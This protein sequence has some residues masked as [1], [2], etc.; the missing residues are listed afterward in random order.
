MK[1][2][3]GSTLFV[4]LLA[5]DVACT[6]QV[7]LGGYTRGAATGS[8]GGVITDANGGGGGGSQ[9]G[10]S[11]SGGCTPVDDGNPC[12]IDV[13]NNGAPANVPL[14][15]GS[16][17]GGGGADA[18]VSLCNAMAECVSTCGTNNYQVA[19]TTDLGPFGDPLSLWVSDINRD[20]FADVAT[21]FPM[22]FQLAPYMGNGDGY[23][24]PAPPGSVGALPPVAMALADVNSDGLLDAVVVG[25]NSDP[26]AG[27]S[28]ISVFL[29]EKQ[30]NGIAFSASMIVT[31]VPA[32]VAENLT[33]N[34]FDADGF[35]DVAIG[36][37]PLVG[38]PAIGPAIYM[39]HGGKNGAFANPV[40]IAAQQSAPKLLRSASFQGKSAADVAYWDGDGLY[41]NGGDPP[42]S[43]TVAP[44]IND[45]S[46]VDFQ[47]VDLDG[48]GLPELVVA[49]QDPAGPGV[50]VLKNLGNYGFSQ[51][52]FWPT[53]YPPDGLS[54]ADLDGD[55][56]LDVVVHSAA[57][58]YNV[59]WFKNVGMGVL[60]KEQVLFSTF[61]N[62]TE[63]RVSDVNGDGMPD[64]LLLSPGQ[65]GPASAAL[66]VYLGSCGP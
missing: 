38:A 53:Q 65:G 43:I 3:L 8:G 39:L 2:R 63:L 55:G 19:R 11:G 22:A 24:S 47:A 7:I 12:T 27:S 51:A 35:L 32:F 59:T 36:G 58:A 28:Q 20:G 44:G 16:Q 66:N 52:M 9:S 48:D 56:L 64:I 25:A 62:G 30:G 61:T 23:F 40:V 4:A 37:Q 46:L 1:L 57:G 49:T 42:F 45:P 13:C 26:M 50:Q 5:L 14:P 29:G 34:D 60:D 18:G 33:V 41:I 21:L 54:I 31:T 17:C 15:K 6:D 10:S